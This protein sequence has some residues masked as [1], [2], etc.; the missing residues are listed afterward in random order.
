VTHQGDIGGSTNSI[1]W[2]TDGLARRGHEVFLCCRP[3]SLL[4]ERFAG[5]ALVRLVPFE[6]GRSPIAPLR[7]R[8]LAREARRRAVEIVNAHAS[9]DRHLTIQARHLFRGGFR[10]VHTRRNMP[11]STGGRL[12]G[13]YYGACT[14]RIIA[15]SARVAEAMARGG[16]PREKLAVVHNGIPLERYREVPA[17]DVEK[18]R[19]ELNLPEGLPVV[20]M[21]ARRKGQDE[22]LRAMASVA[23]PAVI[24]LLGIDRDER[25]ETLRASLHLPH[26]VIY[27]GFRME[28]LPF[29]RLLDVFV[30]PSIIE[31]FSLAILEAMALGLPVVCTDAGGNAEA[32]RDGVNGFLFRPGDSNGLAEGIGRLLSDPAFRL[33]VGKTNREEAFRRF[34]VQETIRKTEEVYRSLVE[35]RIES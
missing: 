22:L 6:F 16:V 27:G 14:D 29:Y 25:L 8:A 3:G 9:L 23:S 35:E 7:S 1:T 5:H 18:A 33:A 30:L 20:G 17:H 13:R 2:L 34:G 26:A 28:I 11:L 32:V 21:F 4:W 15:V 10:L 24:L 19:R 31:G 12:Q